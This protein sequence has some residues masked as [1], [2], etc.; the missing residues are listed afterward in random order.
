MHLRRISLLVHRARLA[1][2]LPT[3]RIIAFII[4]IFLI[5]LSASM[6]IP[7][8]ALLCSNAPTTSAPSP[9]RA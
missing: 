3:L 7:M 4:G 5:T 6:V 2:A 1:M 8:L 9:G